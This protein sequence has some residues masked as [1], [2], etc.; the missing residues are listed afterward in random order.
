[1]EISCLRNVSA[2]SLVSADLHDPSHAEGNPGREFSFVLKRNEVG[3]LGLLALH[4]PRYGA[5]YADW[6]G[7][8]VKRRISDGRR[9]PLA[10][11]VGLR[12][13]RPLRVL[14]ITGGLGRDAYTLAALGAQV[15][16]IERHS[17]IFQLLRDEQ[18]RVFVNQPQEGPA[19]RIQIIHG[20]SNAE[21]PII[22]T[23]FDVIY[24][25]P[26]YPERIKSALPSKE[27]QV[28]REL[29]GGDVDS[30]RLLG[31]ALN[32]GK[33]VVVK[34]GCRSAWLGASRPSTE[35]RGTQVRFDVYL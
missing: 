35:I 34:R 29:T 4:H 32:T 6:L 23:R 18:I 11:A 20:D 19:S 30:W 16:L 21:L 5:V 15:T 2:T 17:L 1:M 14:D 27:M 28:L 10:R 12:K 22:G 31:A 24:L 13:D 9:Q 8:R 26:M 33:R 25:D 3:Q 7:P